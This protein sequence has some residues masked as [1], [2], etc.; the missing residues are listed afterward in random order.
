MASSQNILRS[1]LSDSEYEVLVTKILASFHET[2]DPQLEA[3][4]VAELDGRVVGSINL[5][6]GDEAGLPNCGS[7]I[8]SRMRAVV[9]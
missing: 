2:F 3:V 4:R 7:I 8:S 1:N 6:K 5:V 9:A